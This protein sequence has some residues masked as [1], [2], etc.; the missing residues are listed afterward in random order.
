MPAGHGSGIMWA[1]L[2]A[3]GGWRVNVVRRIQVGAR[4][5]LTPVGLD[6][7]STW[8]ALVAGRS[9]IDWITGFDASC[10][11]VKYA[12]EVR[13]FDPVAYIDRKEARRM[14]RFTQFAVAASL[15]AIAQANLKV[16]RCNADDIGVVMGSG[17]GGIGSL[18]AQ[19]GVLNDK[20]PHRVSPYTVTLMISDIAAGQVAIMTGARGPNFCTTSACASGAHAIGEA[21]EII[22]RG[23]AVA[24]IA[25]GSEAP[26]TPIGVAAFDAMRALSRYEG[27]PQK[28]CRPFD[29]TRDGFVIAEGGAV[30]V[31]EELEFAST[32]GATPPS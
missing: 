30:L 17:I 4:G 15:Q 26:V 1:T 18:S 27:A 31:L 23:D 16:D 8:A 11:E 12:G 28:A 20:G 32:R 19:I 5:M 6:P 7:A 24:M 29:A 9:G 3:G 14:D 2:P 25:G 10:F 22:R 13:G 21:F